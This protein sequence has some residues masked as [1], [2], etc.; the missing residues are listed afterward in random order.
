MGGIVGV[1]QGATHEPRFIHISYQPTGEATKSIALVGKGLTFDSGGLCIK[2]AKGMKDMYIDMGGAA[3]VLGTMHGC[4]TPTRSRCPRH[5]GFMRKQTGPDAY[6]PSDVLTMYS[7]KTVEVI[8]TDAEGR[9]VLADC[10]HYAAQ[11]KP[12]WTIDLATLTGACMVGLGP[13]YAGLFSD[14]EELA[15]SLLSARNQPAR[16]CGECLSIR[17]LLRL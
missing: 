16:R 7:G 4:K 8:N 14:N 11:L 2:P 6:R 1:S 15:E 12:D 9:L 3:A 10:L 5:R 17:S 13:N